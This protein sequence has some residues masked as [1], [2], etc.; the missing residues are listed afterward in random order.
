M[1]LWYSTQYYYYATCILLVSLYTVI[2]ELVDLKRNLKNLKKMADYQCSVTVRRRDNFGRI[3]ER[4][5]NSNDLVPG[6]IFIV[7]ENIKMP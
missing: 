3:D 4:E 2:N 5:I 1:G 6:D 7:P